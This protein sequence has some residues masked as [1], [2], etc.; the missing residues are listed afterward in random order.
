[1]RNLLIAARLPLE[2][3][4]TK[5]A[6]IAALIAEKRGWPERDYRRVI[7]E[8]KK[9]QLAPEQAVVR[10]RERIDFLARLAGKEKIVTF[11]VRDLSIR[12]ATEAESAAV[13]SPHMKPPPLLGKYRR[14]GGIHYLLRAE[15]WPE[16]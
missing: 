8:L 9:E 4:R 1:M 3:S 12:L 5:C 16:I 7:Q 13:P 15:R 10:Y 6:S 14:D 2:R 11:P